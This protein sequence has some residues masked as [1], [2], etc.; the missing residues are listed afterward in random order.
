M[1]PARRGGVKRRRLI[2]WEL[3]RERSKKKE[4]RKK[5]EK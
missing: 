1:I 2:N 4:V 5:S 3:A